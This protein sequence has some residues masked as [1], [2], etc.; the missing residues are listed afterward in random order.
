MAP[1]SPQ[2]LA[3]KSIER[4]VMGAFTKDQLESLGNLERWRQ[5]CERIIAE[6]YPLVRK[7]L[8]EAQ[9]VL[10]RLLAVMFSAAFP[11]HSTL[12]FGSSHS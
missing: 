8:L 5:A 11:G 6:E 2:P 12:P 1:P 4:S 7:S 10:W 9:R 3:A